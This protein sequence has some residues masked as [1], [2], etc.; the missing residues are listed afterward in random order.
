MD[1]QDYEKQVEENRKR[2]DELLNGFGK[3]LASTGISEKTIDRHVSNV[4]FYIN[5]Y[6]T[7]YDVVSAESGYDEIGFFLGDWF[8]RKAMWSSETSIKQNI[9]SLKKFYSYLQQIGMIKDSDYKLLLEIIREEKDDWLRR[10]KL[11]E[12]G[13]FEAFYEMYNVDGFDEPTDNNEDVEEYDPCKDTEDD[14]EDD[15]YKEDLRKLYNAIKNFS[16]AKPWKWLGDTDVFAIKYQDDDID[17][18]YFCC[19]LGSGGQV[20][21]ISIYRGLRGLDSYFKTLHGDFDTP[22]EAIHAM[23]TISIYLKDREDIAE[24]DYHAIQ[25]SGVTFRGKKQWP[26]IKVF[27]PGFLPGSIGEI[28]LWDLID[29]M[30]VATEYVLYLKDNMDKASLF[31]E[32]KYLLREYD[33]NGN[34]KE[35]IKKYDDYYSENNQALDIPILYSELEIKRIAKNCTKTHDVWEIDSFYFISPVEDDGEVFFPAIFMAIDLDSGDIVGQHITHPDFIE[36]FQL[37][38]LEAVTKLDVIPKTVVMKHN[39]NLF[40]L[41]DIFDELDIEVEV[42]DFLE[43]I[44]QIKRDMFDHVE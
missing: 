28:E 7:N 22:E 25:L 44:P 16:A 33:A 23:D 34:F 15:E 24:D 3:W 27:E 29:V 42:V 39:P 20:Y 8:I 31:K 30:E 21:G 26:S 32:G 9:A 2:N 35:Y 43:V 17:D 38:F 13:D 40:P 12:E 37:S 1:Y 14:E 10:L 41:Y 19:I 18:T 5:E 36:E 6:L 4:D 11:Y